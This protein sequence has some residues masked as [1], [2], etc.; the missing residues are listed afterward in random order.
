M[1]AVYVIIIIYTNEVGF[2]EMVMID[3]YLSLCCCATCHQ[4]LYFNDISAMKSLQVAILRT[5]QSLVSP[6]LL[7]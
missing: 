5:Q 6:C 2:Y 3:I 7:L 1:H 4:K